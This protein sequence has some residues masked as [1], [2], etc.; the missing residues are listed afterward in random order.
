MTDPTDAIKQTP[1]AFVA[2]ATGYTGQEVVKALRRRGIRTIA[3]VRP[4]S[5]RRARF[6]AEWTA[7]GAESDSTPWEAEAMAAR[8][9]DLQP[10]LVFA[11]LGTTKSRVSAEKKAGGAGL[12]YEAVDYGM[13]MMV[14]A[15]CEALDPP[16][17]FVYLSALGVREAKP[18]SYYSA[19][20]K[21]E[22][23]LRSS[24][25]PWTIAQPSFIS[26]PDREDSRPME[27]I[28]SILAGPLLKL[29]GRRTVDK[30]GPISAAVLGEGLV[31]HGLDS[32]GARRTVTS[33]DLR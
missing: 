31:R 12:D 8:V 11:L 1:I 21:V 20:W 4:D 19:R 27:R 18:G 26:G 6:E 22:Q 3:H 32:G 29:G 33:A 17:R 10:T 15:G 24:V 14:F 16:P 5:S 9:L 13:T 7:L 23:A 30:W 25:V 28:G 2:G